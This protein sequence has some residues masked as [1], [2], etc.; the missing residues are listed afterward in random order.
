MSC[1]AILVGMLATTLTLYADDWVPKKIVA[2]TDYSPSA[3][4]ARI[5][6]DVVIQCFL[7]STGSVERAEIISG[8]PLF[9]EQALENALLWKFERTSA[10]HSGSDS[11]TLRYQYRLEPG[12][13]G[14]RR[15]FFS[16]DLPNM[17]HIVGEF[18]AVDR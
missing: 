8:H 9:K 3:R 1:L 12:P 18:S 2:I 11:V 10:G 14:T 5:Q 17:I 7:D 15:T 13:E 16:V 6:G 4:K